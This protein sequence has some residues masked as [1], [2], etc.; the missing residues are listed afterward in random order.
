MS[1]VRDPERDQ[2]APTP[3][4]NRPIQDMVVED[5]LERKEHGIRKYGT[6]VQADN[7]RDM[8]LDA[9]EEILDL[10]V[11]LRG[12]IEEGTDFDIRSESTRE[13]RIVS[14]NIPA[15]SRQARGSRYLHETYNVL[16]PGDKIQE[17]YI[18]TTRRVE[19]RDEL[20]PYTQKELKEL[21][22]TRAERES[23]RR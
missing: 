12:A 23:K 1:N 2:V 6:P 20:S 14:D 21:E 4:E 19:W 13:Y 5:I 22:D 11:Y 18:T 3:N 17:K 9:Y 8:M 16:R 10:A 7:G 15:A